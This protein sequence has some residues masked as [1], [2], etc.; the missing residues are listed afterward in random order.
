[1]PWISLSS[2]GSRGAGLITNGDPTVPGNA[3]DATIKPTKD[4]QHLLLW[5]HALNTGLVGDDMDE[6]K[7]HAEVLLSM[8]GFK[9]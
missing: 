6:L 4:R 7:V 9:V 5:I 1:M 8:E 2:I 3:F